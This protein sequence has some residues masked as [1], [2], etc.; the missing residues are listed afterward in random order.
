MPCAQTVTE[1]ALH[2][3]A[4]RKT[5]K[6]SHFTITTSNL[7]KIIKNKMSLNWTNAFTWRCAGASLRLLPKKL[8]SFDV[9]GATQVQK[10]AVNQTTC[11]IWRGPAA[12]AAAASRKTIFA[13]ANF[14]FISAIIFSLHLRYCI[15]FNCLYCMIG[16]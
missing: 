14:C 15:D 7:F 16:S 1:F 2:S 4:A 5:S 12:A 11:K 3:I 9:I 10:Q 8:F 13:K 6:C